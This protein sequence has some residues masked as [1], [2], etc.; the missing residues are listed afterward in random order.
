MF[1]FALGLTML[2]SVWARWRLLRRRDA[3]NFCH[4]GTLT[5]SPL[6]RLGHRHWRG[7]RVT[8]SMY[9]HYCAGGGPGWEKQMIIVLRP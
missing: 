8:G 7:R 4:V 3:L 5:D 2:V 6:S 9:V 1:K